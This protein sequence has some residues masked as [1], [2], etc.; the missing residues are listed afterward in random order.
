VAKAPLPETSAHQYKASP[1][2]R[3]ALRALGLRVRALREARGWT[4]EQAAEAM[5]LDLKHLQKVESGL[6][7][8]T[9]VTLLRIADGFE[10]P[11][12]ELFS[13]SPPEKK[14]TRGR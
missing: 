3:R 7:N 1:R 10:V 9:M 6:L 8:V 2:F 5:A 4:L 12:R 13:E 14:R 11:L